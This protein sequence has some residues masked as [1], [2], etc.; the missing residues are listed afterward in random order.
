MTAPKLLYFTARYRPGSMAVPVHAD[1]LRALAAR[2]YPGAIVTL[3]PPGQPEQVV[4]APDGDLPVYRVAISRGWRDR[5]ANRLAGRRYTYPFLYTAARYIGPWLRRQ[6]AADPDLLLQGEMAF[7]MGAVIR[8]ALAGTPARTVL[9]LHGGD[10]IVPEHGLRYGYA[11]VPAVGA[12]LRKVFAWTGGVRAMSPLLARAAEGFGCAP[13]KIAVVPLNIAD[14]F[15]PT[16]PL[17]EVRARARA[18][19]L[20]E[21]GLPDDARILLANGR[22]LPIKGYDVLV[23]ALPQMLASQPA[24]Y[25]VLYGPDR[26]DTVDTL[27]RQVAGLGLTGHVRLLGPVPFDEQERYLA[28][29]D[30]VVIPSLLDGFNRTGA[31][32][33]AHGTPIVASTGAGIADFVRDYGAGRAVPPRDPAALAAAITGLLADPTAWHA[34]SAGAVRLAAACRTGN[35]ADALAALYA[36]ITPPALTP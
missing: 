7:P 18:A 23:A 21:L 28:G 34:A 1:L 15:Y 5:L 3:A 14:S 16:A 33:G 32:A 36:R 6:L 29:A 12:E 31:E 4:A 35:V 24:T 30:L 22:V 11:Q 25:F 27:R 19:L 17:A 2:G 8:R 13:E 9:T 20:A 10:A 26:G